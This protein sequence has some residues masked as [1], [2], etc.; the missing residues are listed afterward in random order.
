MNFEDPDER[1]TPRE[2]SP[3]PVAVLCTVS[4][5]RG[6]EQ[7]FENFHQ[8]SILGMVFFQVGQFHLLDHH[9]VE[10]PPETQLIK[11]YD[12]IPFH[13]P[14]SLRRQ[15]NIPFLTIVLRASTLQN[16]EINKYTRYKSN[17]P[18]ISLI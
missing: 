15:Y 3:E 12:R 8:R 18:D 11:E 9:F 4:D 17:F 14:V 7:V 13:F 6:V 2:L 10:D 5:T 16:T 1:M